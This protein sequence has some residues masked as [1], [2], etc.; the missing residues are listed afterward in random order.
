M[1]TG[2]IINMAGDQIF[3][4]TTLALLTLVIARVVGNRYPKAVHALWF[5]VLVKFLVPPTLT[6]PISVFDSSP[7]RTASTDSHET[8]PKPNVIPSNVSPTWRDLQHAQTQHAST[9]H[10]Q[11]DASLETN[12]TVD[13][14]DLPAPGIQVATQE[15]CDVSAS[16]TVTS[17]SGHAAT[18]SFVG[19]VPILL[20]VWAAGMLTVFVYRMALTWR[21]LNRLRRNSFSVP[22]E[23]QDR[24]EA[25]RYRL[26]IRSSVQLIVSD[27]CSDPIV[28]GIIRPTVAIPAAMTKQLERSGILDA[29]FAHE[30]MHVR[31]RDSWTGW[32]Q[33]AATTLWWFHPLAWI[34]SRRLS[35]SIEIQCDHDVVLA[36]GEAP[37]NYARHLI[38][39]M[40][41]I[42]DAAAGEPSRRRPPLVLGMGSKEFTRIRMERI[43]T[44]KK[45]A[46]IWRYSRLVAIAMVAAAVWPGQAN[47]TPPTKPVDSKT[48][49]PRDKALSDESLSDGPIVA[50]TYDLSDMFER[51]ADGAEN[52][53]QLRKHFESDLRGWLSL[54]YEDQR[55][56]AWTG[57][58][59]HVFAT[60]T[61][62]G[63]IAKIIQRLRSEDR[64]TISVNSRMFR[65]QYR[66]A[67]QALADL[68]LEW[69][70]MPSDAAGLG[71]P[72]GLGD[73]IESRHLASVAPWSARVRREQE[74]HV[75]L[76]AAVL[77][78][79]QWE[80]VKQR[81][82]ANGK[83]DTGA[84]RV[85]LLEG[86]QA[87][88]HSG[89][90]KPFVVGVSSGDGD[91]SELNPNHD[92]LYDG[93]EL[94]LFARRVAQQRLRIATTWTTSS[95]SDVN[96]LRLSTAHHDSIAV[97][98]PSVVRET[99]ATMFETNSGQTVLLGSIRPNPD[100][101]PSS[102]GQ[103]DFVVL[104]ITCTNQAG[105]PKDWIPAL[106]SSAKHKMVRIEG[107]PDVQ[108]SSANRASQA[109][110][111]WEKLPEAAHRLIGQHGLTV[112]TT[113]LADLVVRHNQQ[114]REISVQADQ[115]LMECMDTEKGEPLVSL[116]T[117]EL[118]VA[119]PADS[120]DDLVRIRCTGRTKVST[121][122]GSE[123]RADEVLLALEVDEQGERH[124]SLEA[125]GVTQIRHRSLEARSNN[126]VL[127]AT[128]AGLQLEG[129]AQI[130]LDDTQ[131][132]TV[133]ADRIRINR[134]GLLSIERR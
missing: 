74:E 102:E 67:K 6:G 47:S 130:R 121:N 99:V 78:P 39:A 52:V 113:G 53:D 18:N 117:S 100:G 43:M 64:A 122:D 57:E 118:E 65:C 110:T 96:E 119:M 120:G 81:L 114:G 17:Q 51:Y 112:Q 15:R 2:D 101:R 83:S 42:A 111:R 61:E 107:F 14:S 36:T 82:S 12:A 20:L 54:S 7:F 27:K 71:T 35:R 126:A 41:I 88:I 40:K 22:A 4:V 8:D 87:L 89:V 86:Q 44:T 50:K 124:L 55:R 69:F 76:F 31:R 38:D 1:S 128:E 66:Q 13:Q 84:P 60:E 68:S 49:E 94:G 34:V 105:G 29:T 16:H 133:T 56:L 95:V 77:S 75:P 70:L 26:G 19:L 21:H 72:T 80:T 30:L 97:Q 28:W 115:V 127:R 63:T 5:V 62:Q 73:V 103:R 59:L 123:V 32:L 33:F 79:Q 104:A 37:A 125:K 116:T 58:T 10:P 98:S 132:N 93:F 91:A 9:L 3:Q 45:E 48:I 46:R 24:F 11:G 25:M 108:R 92:V 109:G 129:D 131:G 90:S 134:N 106:D 23:V 85:T